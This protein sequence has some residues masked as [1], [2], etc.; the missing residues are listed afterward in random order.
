MISINIFLKVN[1]KLPAHL[2]YFNS[3]GSKCI[4]NQKQIAKNPIEPLKITKKN[5]KTTTK[6]I[7]NN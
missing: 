6:M 2:N 1:C 7:E 5:K 4:K 3:V